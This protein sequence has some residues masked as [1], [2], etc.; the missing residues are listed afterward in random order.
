MTLRSAFRRKNA[1]VSNT[2]T[3]G[4]KRKSKMNKGR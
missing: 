3:T 4:G 1:G 2:A